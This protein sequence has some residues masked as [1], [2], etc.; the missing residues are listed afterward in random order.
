[1]TVLTLGQWLLFAQA[2]T[3][4]PG[5]ETKCQDNQTCCLVGQKVY[6][7]CLFPNAVCCSD[8]QHCCPEH[9]QCIDGMCI[10]DG[11]TIPAVKNLIAKSEQVSK[12]YMIY[13]EL[14]SSFFRW[15]SIPNFQKQ[16]CLNL[17]SIPVPFLQWI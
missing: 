5:G 3:V 8:K 15:S 17:A 13:S 14:M 4:C 10:Q 11:H 12:I 7:C 2:D 6:G 1:M 9:Y 16:Y